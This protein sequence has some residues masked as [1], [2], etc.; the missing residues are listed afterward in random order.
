MQRRTFE[1]NRIKL[2]L[3]FWWVSISI[4]VQVN[5]IT[6]FTQPASA[7]IKPD[8]ISNQEE[9]KDLPWN[10]KKVDHFIYN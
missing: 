6:R 8:T 3:R 5:T 9:T 2:S 10:E 4:S 1:C 7:H